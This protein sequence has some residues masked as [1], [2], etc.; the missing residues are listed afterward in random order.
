[1]AFKMKG[2]SFYGAGNQSKSK[3]SPLD[4]DVK[5]IA[6]KLGKMSEDPNSPAASYASP[7]KNVADPRHPHNK[8][9]EHVMTTTRTDTSETRSKGGK[10]STYNITNTKDNR[11]GSKTHTFTN[12]LGNSYK[13]NH[14]SR[15]S[16]KKEI[17]DNKK[18]SPTDYAS[19]AKQTTETV[20]YIEGA[21]KKTTT[22]QKLKALAKTAVSG[23]SYKSNK[24][25][26]RSTDYR[27]DKK[28]PSAQEM[29]A[30]IKANPD[31]D[32]GKSRIY[33]IGVS[34]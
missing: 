3:H 9:G 19:P 18:S 22:K 13:A 32:K 25:K 30:Y 6:G 1:M 21:P 2:S 24:A 14:S 15:P 17:A 7:A 34:R 23:G 33:N 10:T 8:K 11:D 16:T 27:K 4:M 31:K 5:G 20:D 28:A 12:E 29:K 26:E